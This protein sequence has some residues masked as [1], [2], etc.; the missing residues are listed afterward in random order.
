MF[1]DR[2]SVQRFE[3]GEAQG[4]WTA[5]YVDLQR[6][7]FTHRWIILWA[8]PGRFLRVRIDR[9]HAED[10]FECL[11]DRVAAANPDCVVVEEG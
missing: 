4:R 10:V 3:R 5:D 2:L 11:S 9:L 1:E 6:I 8:E 7:E